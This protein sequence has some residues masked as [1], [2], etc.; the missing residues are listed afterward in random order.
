MNE[1]ETEEAY[2]AEE[3]RKKCLVDFEVFKVRVAIIK[4]NEDA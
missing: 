3:Y 1:R 2:L 4:G